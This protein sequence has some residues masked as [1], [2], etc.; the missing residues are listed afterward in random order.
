MRK[1][2][3]QQ[4]AVGAV[5]A[6]I[7][8]PPFPMPAP[9][10]ATFEP[11]HARVVQTHCWR[12]ELH[13]T[14]GAL[15]WGWEGVLPIGAYGSRARAEAKAKRIIDRLNRRDLRQRAAEAAATEVR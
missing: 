14:S 4:R 3:G 5:P 7:T 10:R 6:R 12:Y 13:I 11:W 9:P 8:P 2:H 1:Q 15:R